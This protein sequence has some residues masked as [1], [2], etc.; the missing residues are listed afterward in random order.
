MQIH[1]HEPLY[2]LSEFSA[3]GVTAFLSSFADHF[4]TR[5]PVLHVTFDAMSTV[6]ETE[7][8]AD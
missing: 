1:L 7:A 8:R 3:L 2:K 5:R 6:R 4:P